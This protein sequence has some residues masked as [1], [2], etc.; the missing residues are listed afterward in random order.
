MGDP[1]LDEYRNFLS[2]AEQAASTSYD[3]AVMTLAGGAFGLSFVFLKDFL[4]PAKPQGMGLLIS[5]WVLL[6][7]SIV[8]ILVSILTGRWS[9]RKAISQLDQQKIYSEKPGAWLSLLT[10]TL[11]VLAA[12]FFVGGVAF[13]AWFAVK[14]VGTN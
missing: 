9:L 11:N 6:A 1:K 5:G 2:N 3:K 12:V 8:S 10:E 7:L 13:L 14:N 4:G